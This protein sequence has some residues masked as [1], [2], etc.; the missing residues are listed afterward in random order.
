MMPP[1]GTLGGKSMPAS[2]AGAAFNRLAGRRVLIT[3][4]A[5]GIGKS[6]AQLF[7]REGASVALLDLNKDALTEVA[8]ELNGRAYPIDL[9]QAELIEPTVGRAAKE[10]GGLDGVVNCAG[11]G[12][13]TAI[14]N[15]DIPLL[16]KF[17]A[18]NLTAPYL[19]C[20]AALPYLR[21]AE[22]S[23]IVNISSGAGLLPTSPNNTAYAATKGGVI[24][25]S[26]ALAVEVAPRV[27]VNV[28]CPGLTRTP[29]TQFLFDGHED[30]TQ[31][32][33]LQQYPL[34]RVGE[35]EEIAR[36]VLFL[37]SDES[38]FITGDAIAVDGGRCLH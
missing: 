28:V 26:K 25:F 17:V 13:P 32:P 18:I 4:A 33:F 21:V 35:P 12:V 1:S 24:A 27:R 30:P 23:T 20:R 8:R 37:S 15:T 9:A 11:I 36:A 19:L 5:S 31:I 10:L 7:S 22:G 34:R 29:M 38:S 3:G 14:E 16:A 2:K 6:I